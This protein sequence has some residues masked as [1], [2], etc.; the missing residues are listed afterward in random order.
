[1]YFK[2]PW[3]FRSLT[4]CNFA[5]ISPWNLYSFEIRKILTF[6]IFFFIYK[7]NFAAH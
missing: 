5:V 1:M 7:Q 4:I 2:V 6:S 3:K